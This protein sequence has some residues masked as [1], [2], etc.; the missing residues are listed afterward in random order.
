MCLLIVT[1]HSQH[2]SRQGPRRVG[3]VRQ[4]LPHGGVPPRAIDSSL[5]LQEL[6]YNS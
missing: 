3:G 2:L 1:I 4:P 5:H 6:S